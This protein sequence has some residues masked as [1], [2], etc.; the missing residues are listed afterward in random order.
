MALSPQEA[1]RRLK[2]AIADKAREKEEKIDKAL[3]A[4]TRTISVQG[5]SSELIGEI[6]RRF[7]VAGWRVRF[8]SDQRDGNFLEFEE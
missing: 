1:K 6:S 2:S 4:G 8:T 7:R 3:A 5:W